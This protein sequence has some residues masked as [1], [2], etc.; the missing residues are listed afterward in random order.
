[1]GRLKNGLT[2]WAPPYG[3]PSSVLGSTNRNSPDKEGTDEDNPSLKEFS[4]RASRSR[5]GKV[6]L[7]VLALALEKTFCTQILHNSTLCKMHLSIKVPVL[8]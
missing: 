2:G 1:M 6:V 5:S 3:L 4:P 8:Y 7:V